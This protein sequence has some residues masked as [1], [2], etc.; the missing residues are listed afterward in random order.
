MPLNDEPSLQTVIKNYEEKNK[1]RQEIFAAPPQKEV[2]VESAVKKI[3][4]VNPQKKKSKHQKVDG[5]SLEAINEQT[6]NE[7]TLD[8]E[9]SKR[10]PMTGQ[11]GPFLNEL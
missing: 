2:D 8:N 10:G 3:Q 11:R 9:I 4:S 7:V 5:N 1:L 6:S